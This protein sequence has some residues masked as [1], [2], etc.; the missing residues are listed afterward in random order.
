M[1]CQE[2]QP[3][4]AQPGLRFGDDSQRAVYC[5]ALGTQGI[6][7]DGHYEVQGARVGHADHMAF[8]PLAN[9]AGERQRTAVVG[10]CRFEALRPAGSRPRFVNDGNTL[11]GGIDRGTAWRARSRRNA[12]WRRSTPSKAEPRTP[13]R[14][15]RMSRRARPRSA[16]GA[17]A[18]TAPLPLFTKVQG[19]T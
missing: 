9:A 16:R 2:V 18:A 5:H 7:D 12:A 10:E 14:R 19:G 11:F 4:L 17:P 15:P 8:H 3:L 13:T 1:P 6:A